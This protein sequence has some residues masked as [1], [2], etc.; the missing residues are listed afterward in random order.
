[1]FSCLERHGITGPSKVMWAKD[2]DVRNLL[3]RLGE[4]IHS[5]TDDIE[6]WK[7]GLVEAANAVFKAVQEMVYK[8][9]NILLPMSLETLSEDEWAEI[10][11][12]SPIDLCIK[13]AIH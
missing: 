2:D 6:K 3:T 11:S 1:L 8:E 4:C 10:W 7:V 13:N 5:G 9:E 12:V